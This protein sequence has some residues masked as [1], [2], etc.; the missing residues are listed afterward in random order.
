[1]SIPPYPLA[2]PEGLPRTLNREELRVKATLPGAL[3]NV[4]TSLRLFGQDTGKA[5]T[6]CEA[7]MKR[8]G[9]A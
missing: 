3:E 1:M 8:E 6:A 5:V 7:R 4:R 9:R 2:W